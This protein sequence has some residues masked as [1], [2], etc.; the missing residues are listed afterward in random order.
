MYENM[1]IL[2]PFI[3]FLTVIYIKHFHNVKKEKKIH[4]SSPIR[5]LRTET[6]RMPPVTC[7]LTGVWQ[8]SQKKRVG[9]KPGALTRSW[10][11]CGMMQPLWGGIRRH[12]TN[13]CLPLYPAVSFLGFNPQTH[14]RTCEPDCDRGCP[15]RHCL[16]QQNTRNNLDV[17]TQETGWKTELSTQCRA[18]QP[19]LKEEDNLYEAICPVKENKNQGAWRVKAVTSFV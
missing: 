9:E 17:L 18:V 2:P 3:W 16:W 6:T 15:L 19:F 13:R 8:L 12:L 14:A 10:W 5:E 7:R 11:D 1:L 4:S